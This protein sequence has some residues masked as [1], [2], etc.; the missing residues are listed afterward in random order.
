MTIK[1]IDLAIVGAASLA[2]EAV[3][4]LLA[5]RKFPVG[6]LYAVDVVEQSGSH[7]EYKDEP[8]VVHELAEFDFEKVQLAIFLVEAPLAAE[9]APRAANS[10]CIV[11]DS[12][13]CFRHEADVPLVLAGVND[14]QMGDYRNRMILSQPSAATAQLLR[15]IKP[16]ADEAGL[17]ELVLTVLQSVSEMGKSGQEELGRQTAQ[18]LNFQDVT[19]SV[20]PAQIAFNLIPQAG[21]QVE[22]GHT[23]AE[24]DL[25]RATHKAL[26]NDKIS[27]Q[28][29]VVNV[30]VFFGTAI[31][32]ALRTSSPIREDKIVELLDNAPGVRVVKTTTKTSVTPVTDASGKDEVIIDRIRHEY[33]G[34]ER[35]LSLWCVADNIRSGVA[36]NSVQIAE[37]LVKDHL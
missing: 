34:D 37:I 35:S 31:S 18:L 17:D 26:N 5:E 1:Q 28:A 9:Y 2:G 20:F 19:K 13:I 6:T 32:L 21:I 36:I 30:P 23:S 15:V 12:S 27:I 11:V 24:L 16:I 14:E 22:G 25:I 8:V 10:G 7:V 4:S 3:L 29:T 33:M